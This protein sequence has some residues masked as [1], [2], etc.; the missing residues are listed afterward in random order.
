MRQAADKKEKDQTVLDV[1]QA[2]GVQ[3]MLRG[4]GA[5][6]VADQDSQLVAFAKPGLAFQA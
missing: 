2:V 1:G 3:Q 5:V 4:V 6:S